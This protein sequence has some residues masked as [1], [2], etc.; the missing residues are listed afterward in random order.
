MMRTC[1]R[2]VTLAFTCFLTAAALVLLVA[3]P[4]ALTAQHVGGHSLRL[5]SGVQAQPPYT[6]SVFAQSVKGQYTQPDSI[7]FSST[8]IFIGYGNGGSPNGS[9]STP[10]T[11][12]QYDFNGNVLNR[13][14]VGGHND[15]LKINPQTGDL[16]SLQNEDANATLIIFNPQ[17]LTIK[18]KYFLGTG[19]HGGGYDDVVFLNGNVYISASNP[20]NNPNNQPAIVQFTSNGN[21]FTLTPVVYGNASATDIPTGQGVVLNLQDPDSMTFN[22]GGDIVLDSQADGELVVVR[23]PS[24]SNQSVFRVLL[25]VGGQGTTVDD[26]VFLTTSSGTLLVADRNGETVYAITAP[27][28][29]PG[30]AYSASDSGGFVGQLD[31]STGVL[32]P[33]VTGM[34]SPHGMAFV[35]Q[36]TQSLG[37]VGVLQNP[38]GPRTF[39]P[40]LTRRYEGIL[41]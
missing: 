15:G 34:K 24:G 41:G 16:W 19:P 27:F 38:K 9:T 17:N 18:Q 1:S 10:S 30:S 39:S 3:D 14:F 29:E 35:P 21:S 32:N 23:N 33:V 12:V 13:I 20:Q 8:A 6:V 31:F 37:W 11:I 26:T 28:L 5:D 25:T 2:I 4:S 7:T 22:V 36:P 40:G